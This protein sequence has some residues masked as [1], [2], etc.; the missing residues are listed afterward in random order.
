MKTAGEQNNNKQQH[1]LHILGEMETNMMKQLQTKWQ[2]SM[3]TNAN[4]CGAF[5]LLCNS[6]ISC[7]FHELQTVMQQK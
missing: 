7:E 3:L 6:F 2:A 4:E 1:F 5:E